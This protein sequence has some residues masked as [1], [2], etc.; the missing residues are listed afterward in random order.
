MGLYYPIE[1]LGFRLPVIL[2]GLILIL[3]GVAELL[4]RRL[5]TV[6]AVLRTLI[7]SAVVIAIV[8]VPIIF[9]T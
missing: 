2:G 9:W 7:A 8:A 3:L 5:R 4:P 1:G 6:S